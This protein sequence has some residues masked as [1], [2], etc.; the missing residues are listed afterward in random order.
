MQLLAHTNDPLTR[1]GLQSAMAQKLLKLQ[2][3]IDA[4]PDV[5]EDSVLY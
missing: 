3:R 1:E 2:K 5:N 4:L